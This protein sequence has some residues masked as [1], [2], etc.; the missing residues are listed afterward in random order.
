MNW[1]SLILS[2]WI[3]SFLGIYLAISINTILIEVSLNAF[4]NLYFGGIFVMLGLV[5]MYRV[6]SKNKI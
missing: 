5:L 6:N 3:G 1:A 2:T 4:F